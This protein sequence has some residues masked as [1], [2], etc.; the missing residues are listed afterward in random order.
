MS[1][2]Y[3]LQGSLRGKD[4]TSEAGLANRLHLKK[5]DQM[6]DDEK[7]KPL[8][9]VQLI[10]FKTIRVSAVTSDLSQFLFPGEKEGQELFF[11]RN[12]DIPFWVPKRLTEQ[13]F[14]CCLNSD[15][16]KAR[17]I[18]E[19]Y[20]FVCHYVDPKWKEEFSKICTM[21]IRKQMKNNIIKFPFQKKDS[22]NNTNGD[23]DEIS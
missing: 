20:E 7:Y 13:I 3:D 11:E 21:E 22:V 6:H 4:S 19:F 16:L 1:I 14:I 12:F 8:L 15:E 17:M 18:D 9:E 23:N 2:P 5:G 10:N